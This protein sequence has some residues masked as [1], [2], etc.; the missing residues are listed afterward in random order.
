MEAEAAA[1]YF[2]ILVSA[3]VSDVRYLK[4]INF[5]LIVFILRLTIR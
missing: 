1:I 4:K 3:F 5:N 2:P